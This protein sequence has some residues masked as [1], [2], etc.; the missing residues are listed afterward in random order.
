MDILVPSLKVGAAA[1]TV[2]E[3]SAGH[4]L[5]MF[6]DSLKVHAGFSLERR[7]ASFGLRLQ[8]SSQ[9]SPED[10]GLLWALAT[11]VS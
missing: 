5:S 1:G 8:Y 10:S 9:S 6:S 3:L 2:P 4:V 11:M 7:Q